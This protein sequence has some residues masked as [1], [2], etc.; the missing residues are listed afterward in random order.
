M[1]CPFSFQV[2]IDPSG[3]FALLVEAGGRTHLLHIDESYEGSD[4][5]QEYAIR[6]ADRGVGR[7]NFAFGAAFTAFNDLVVF[8][9]IGG[10]VMVWDRKKGRV[11]YELD[12]GIGKCFGFAI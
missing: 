3:E 12:H 5:V 4:I 9:S 6:N 8:G 7:T 1:R 2:N 11:L 10:R